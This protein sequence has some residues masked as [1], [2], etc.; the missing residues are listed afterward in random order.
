MQTKPIYTHYAKPEAYYDNCPGLVS[1]APEYS[2]QVLYCIVFLFF[3]KQTLLTERDKWNSDCNHSLINN[4][5][6]YFVE[7]IATLRTSSYPLPTSCAE[8]SPADA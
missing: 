1:S 4:L 3:W 8:S 7:G 2:G 5:L 6:I